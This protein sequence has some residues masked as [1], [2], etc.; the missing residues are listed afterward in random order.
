MALSLI[1]VRSSPENAS[2]NDR[3]SHRKMFLLTIY[4]ALGLWLTSC[5][6]WQ[7]IVIRGSQEYSL[8]IWAKNLLLWHIVVLAWPIVCPLT[9]CFEPQ[10]D[11]NWHDC[12]DSAFPAGS[13]LKLHASG[14]VIPDV[15]QSGE[16]CIFGDSP[17]RSLLDGVQ[18]RRAIFSEIGH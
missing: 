4:S 6:D 18:S 14:R 15:Y 9:H 1:G 17:P 11:L 8:T 16:V 12:F 5:Q 7:N 3:T 10:L 2:S 13:I